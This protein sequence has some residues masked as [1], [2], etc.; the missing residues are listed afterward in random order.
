LIAQLFQ[1]EYF[2]LL[3]EHVLLE[4]FELLRVLERVSGRKRATTTDTATLTQQGQ[5]LIALLVKLESFESFLFGQEELLIYFDLF[6][7]SYGHLLQIGECHFGDVIKT[8]ATLMMIM[9][10][11]M[12]IVAAN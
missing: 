10:M 8:D 7:L 3:S 9:M 6:L 4:I 1:L 11:M 5:L 12:V 2:Q